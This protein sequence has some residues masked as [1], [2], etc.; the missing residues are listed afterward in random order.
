MT[1]THHYPANPGAVQSIVAPH[2]A[3]IGARRDML[4]QDVTLAGSLL[5][6][7]EATMADALMEWRYSHGPARDGNRGRA[8]LAVERVKY[9]REVAAAALSRLAGWREAA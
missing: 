3:C 8:R 9:W 6:H 5:R 1:T 2:M 4:S 7:A